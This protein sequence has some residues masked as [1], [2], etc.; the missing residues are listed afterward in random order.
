M[1]YRFNDNPPKPEDHLRKFAVRN[2][3][4]MRI[5]FGCYYLQG[6]NPKM[7]DHIGWPNPDNPDHICQEISNMRLYGL[8]EKT[9]ELEKIHLIEEGYD[10][11]AISFEDSDNAQHLETNVWIDPDDDNIVRLTVKADFPTFSD[12]PI[13]L[14]FTVF[15]K[16]SDGSAIDS[17]CHGMITVLP[18]APYPNI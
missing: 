1:G 7:H 9:A 3:T 16:K 5:A 11:L 6:H 13:D 17:I 2:G 15:A 10:E 12:K 8:K 4:I 18:G 14:R